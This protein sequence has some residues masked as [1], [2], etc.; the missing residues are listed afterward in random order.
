MDFAVFWSSVEL[1]V[2]VFPHHA[3]W[4]LALMWCFVSYIHSSFIH[5]FL[6]SL[7]CQEHAFAYVS[8]LS[9]PFQLLPS[10]APPCRRPTRL[11]SADCIHTTLKRAPLGVAPDDSSVGSIGRV[12]VYFCGVT[13]LSSTSFRAWVWFWCHQSPSHRIG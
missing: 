5:S 12:R 8:I 4:A 10:I 7:D 3:S 9:T 2:V 13:A 11:L 1:S 6:R